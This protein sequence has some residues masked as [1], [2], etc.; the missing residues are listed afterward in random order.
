MAR[1]ACERHGV[2]FPAP[3]VLYFFLLADVSTGRKAPQTTRTVNVVDTGY[4]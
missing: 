4:C 1:F 3:P 2:R